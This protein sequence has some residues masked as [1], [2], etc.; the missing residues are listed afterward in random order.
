MTTETKP[1]R[2]R[3]FTLAERMKLFPLDF[4][5]HLDRN[6]KA[7]VTV[8]ESWERQN[9]VRIGPFDGANQ[10]VFSPRVHIMA[11]NVFSVF[12]FAVEKDPLSSVDTYN[13]ILSYDGGYVPRLKRGVE[14]PLAGSP[15]SAY[16][17]KL[18]N[19]SRGSAI[20]LNAAWNAM[21][22]SGAAEGQKGYL[23][24]VIAIADTIR[25]KQ[26]GMELG[27]VCGAHW[28]GSSIDPM[29]FEIGIWP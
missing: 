7:A 25:V 12:L 11:A 14:L 18:S 6:G 13:D 22:K 23:G 15:K 3:Q 10:L 29:H 8:R 1:L 20:D 16:E 4:E 9:L 24:R 5:V 27:I 19:H 28:K 26:D 21:G 17:S 2:P